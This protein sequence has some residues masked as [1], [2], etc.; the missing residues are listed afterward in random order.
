MTAPADEAEGEAS[1]GPGMILSPQQAV[2]SP[3]QAVLGTQQAVLGNQHA[4]LSTQQEAVLRFE[5]HAYKHASAKEEAIRAQFSLPASRY[6]QI[7]NAT[8][9][10]PAA[11]VFDPMLVKRLL[12][13]RDA[14]T[15]ARSARMLGNS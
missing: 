2:L 4:G 11:M 8:L 6:Y 14:R 15:G 9:E 3:Q 1:T 5:R 13:L 12:R 7:L 10:E